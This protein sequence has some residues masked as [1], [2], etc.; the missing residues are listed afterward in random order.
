MQKVTLFLPGTLH[1]KMR[2]RGEISW[3]S[4]ARKSIS[5][6]IRDLEFMDN[7]TKRSK[8]TS[9]EIEKVSSTINKDVFKDLNKR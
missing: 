5:D 8:F 7:Q 4:V 1:E 2:L 3:R 9:S 6:T